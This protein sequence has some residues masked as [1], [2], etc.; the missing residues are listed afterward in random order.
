MLIGR[1]FFLVGTFPPRHIPD[2]EAASSANQRHFTFQP[3]LATNILRQNET[4]LFIG[5]AMLCAGMQLAQ[6]N[7]AVAWRDARAL[8]NRSPHASALLRG[9]DKEK[10]ISGIR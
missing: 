5:H 9:R 4:T 6:K 8:F 10:L 7:A 1:R 3:D 2:F